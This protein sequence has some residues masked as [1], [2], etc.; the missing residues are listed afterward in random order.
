MKKEQH[1]VFRKYTREYLSQQTGYSRCYLSKVSTGK[2][3]LTRTFI[4]MVSYRLGEP[5]DQLFL[6]DTAGAAPAGAAHN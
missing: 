6:V 5:E 2:M 4:Q 1:P 3:P